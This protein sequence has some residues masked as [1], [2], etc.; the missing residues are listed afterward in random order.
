M[1]CLVA[2][3]QTSFTKKLEQSFNPEGVFKPKSARFKSLL[4]SV[5]DSG[6]R[7]LVAT[8]RRE[9]TSTCNRGIFNGLTLKHIGRI[10]CGF[11]YGLC[12]DYDLY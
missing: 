8:G 3:K 5:V 2:V 4:P 11:N 6:G 7:S 1:F 10:F 12:N 9:N